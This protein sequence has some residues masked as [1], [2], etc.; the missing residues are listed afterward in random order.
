M[1]KQNDIAK[2]LNMTFQE[3]HRQFERLINGGL[4]KK[5]KDRFYR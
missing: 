1:Y 2:E 5:N 3:S 4:V